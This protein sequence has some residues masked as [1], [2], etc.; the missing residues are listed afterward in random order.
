MKNLSF[1][2]WKKIDRLTWIPVLLLLSLFIYAC[3]P[4]KEEIKAQY[5]AHEQ[6]ELH[7]VAI[8]IDE[9]NCEEY[10]AT[11]YKADSCDYIGRLKNCTSDVLAH[12]GQCRRCEKRKIHLMDSLIKVNLKHF[13]SIEKK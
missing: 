9:C 10:I 6:Q 4:T 11:Y 5:E 8:T 3:G 2:S 12:S 1:Y 13:F 7:K